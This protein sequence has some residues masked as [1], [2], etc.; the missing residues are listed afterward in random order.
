MGLV[1]RE[2]TRDEDLEVVVYWVNEKGRSWPT[3][4]D[5]VPLQEST[6]KPYPLN[7]DGLPNPTLKVKPARIRC[8]LKTLS[9]IENNNIVDA[10]LKTKARRT[11]R[12]R[13]APVEVEQS[14]SIA[15]SCSL[16][17][18]AA[19]VKWEGIVMEDGKEAPINDKYLDLLPAWLAD[20]LVDKI[21]ALTSITE[22]EEGE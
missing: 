18:K 9:G 14:T 10:V 19:L 20:D 3:N 11:S 8:W 21:T 16:K 17:L 15:L 12:R 6:D 5:G 13:N 2:Q 1:L 7:G 22:E 4:S